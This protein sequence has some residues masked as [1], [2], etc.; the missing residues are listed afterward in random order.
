M[1]GRTMEDQNSSIQVVSTQASSQ[2]S[3]QT[4][5]FGSYKIWRY[6]QGGIL[7][8]YLENDAFR[9]RKVSTMEINYTVKRALLY[10]L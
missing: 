8:Q 4:C 2:G 3:F 1:P 10:I 7:K 5:C 9:W 6:G